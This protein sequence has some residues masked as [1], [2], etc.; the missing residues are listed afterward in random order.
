MRKIPPG[1]LGDHHQDISALHNKP[2]KG[3]KEDGAK[4]V[5]GLKPADL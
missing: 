5:V 4:G 2:Y 1:L 3:L